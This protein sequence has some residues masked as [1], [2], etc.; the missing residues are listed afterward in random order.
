MAN[1][2]TLQER[3]L[4]V[5][6]KAERGEKFSLSEAITIKEALA[7]PD[8]SLLVRQTVIDTMRDT[9]EP[10][11]IA[12]RLLQKVRVTEGRSIVFPSI[13]D[14]R[15]HEV[16]ELMEYP[17]EQADIQL[18]GAEV[19]VKVQK[20]GLV[21]ELSEEMIEDSQWDIVGILLRKAGRAM[22]RHL[23]EKCFRE[24]ARHGHVIWDGSV[25][26]SSGQ[27]IADTPEGLAPTG[28]DVDGKLNGT[29]AV[30]DIFDMFLG[31]MANEMSGTD[32]LIHPLVWPIFA[33]N[34][35]LSKLPMG[36]FGNEE[37]N[38]ITIRPGDIGGKLPVPI[39]VE[40]S[41]FLQFDRVNK[42]FNF[43]VIDRENIGVL[44]EKDDIGT[45]EWR[46][47]EREIRAIK[48][49]ARNG[50]GILYNG[51]GIMVAQNINYAKTYNLPERI[52]IVS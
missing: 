13:A 6:E 46:N 15:A 11:Y 9:A 14:M 32:I 42:R 39:T 26:D 44:L 48:V 22:A 52:K 18:H 2:L 49:R 25:I 34:E 12:S 1:E 43:Y 16:G 19:E 31:L 7:S 37:N 29:L 45:E 50:V 28:V 4:Q 36:A 33:K 40:F 17:R 3:F 41:P 30:E 10:M 35:M 38:K 23:E 8:L 5:A 21:V 20:Y 51:S 24:F 27:I 47:P